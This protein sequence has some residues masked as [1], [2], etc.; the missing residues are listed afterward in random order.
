MDVKPLWGA[1][2]S[3]LVTTACSKKSSESVFPEN[4]ESTT[5]ACEAQRIET[6]FLVV[7]EDGKIT[8]ETAK[9][10]DEFV[11]DFLEKNLDLIRHVEFDKRIQKKP[12]LTFDFAESSAFA[13]DDWGQVITEAQAAWSQGVL[14]QGVSVAV[15][16]AAVDYTHPQLSPR[17][18]VNSKEKNG[19]PGKDDDGNGYVDDVYGWDFIS[20]SPVPEPAT[21]G[22]TDHGSHVAGIIAADHR[23]GPVKGVAPESRVIPVNFMDNQ[24]GGTLTDA[25]LAIKY[26]VLRG[27]QVI[28]ASWGGFYCSQTLKD[29]VAWLDQKNVLFVTAAGNEGIDFDWYGS[30]YYV[31]PAVFNLPSQITVAATSWSDYMTGFSNRSY[32]YVHLSA[33]GDYILSTV[34]GGSHYMSGTSMASPFVAGAASLLLSHRPQA[35]A[36]QVRE[37]L[38]RSVDVVSGKEQKVLS[39]GRL[40]IKKAL[41]EIEKF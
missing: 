12:V 32:K 8:R 16:D 36:R 14:G 20:N 26:A 21:S 30:Q 34:R 11:N 17:L 22:E 37:A 7:W 23:Y 35:S 38:L 19:S 10:A 29:T 40:N 27:A 5:P 28:N 25:I 39:R 24:G 4:H 6:Q 9:N 1:L 31:Y 33:P 41:E 2:L 15:V 3:L 13:N 18:A